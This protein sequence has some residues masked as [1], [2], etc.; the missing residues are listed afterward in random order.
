MVS[1]AVRVAERTQEDPALALLLAVL[2]RQFLRMPLGQHCGHV[3]GKRMW[4]VLPPR[5]SRT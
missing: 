3:A 5:K 1:P 2:D 4:L